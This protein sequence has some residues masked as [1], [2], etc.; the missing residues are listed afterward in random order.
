MLETIFSATTSSEL[1]V[2]TQDLSWYLK[3]IMQNFYF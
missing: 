3:K 2:L 1:Q